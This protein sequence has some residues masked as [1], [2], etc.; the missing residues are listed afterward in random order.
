MPV[1]AFVMMADNGCDFEI[2]LDLRQDPLADGRVLFHHLALFKSQGPR[3]LEQAR[4]EADLSD[5]VDEPREVGEFLIPLGKTEAL[6]YISGVHG[7]SSGVTRGIAV[8][9]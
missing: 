3:L 2:A 6:G 9:S 5:V 4:G 1:D 7:H 8:T